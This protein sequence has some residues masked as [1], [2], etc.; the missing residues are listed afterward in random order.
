MR[1][2]STHCTVALFGCSHIQNKAVW[3]TV[4]T[5]L[6]CQIIC[7]CNLCSYSLPTHTHSPSFV[8]C[9][10]SVIVM[11]HYFFLNFSSLSLQFILI[12]KVNSFKESDGFSESIFGDKGEHC[13]LWGSTTRWHKV[14]STFLKNGY[15]HQGYYK[16]PIPTQYLLPHTEEYKP[17]FLFS[18]KV[19]NWISF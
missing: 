18:K 11:N 9:H 6:T 14:H 8:S 4:Q 19:L 15:G 7:L 10:H 16:V 12:Q 17:F 5:F 13:F 3:R 2:I 1:T